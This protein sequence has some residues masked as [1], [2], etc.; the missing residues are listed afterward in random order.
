M[1]VTHQHQHLVLPQEHALSLRLAAQAQAAAA[2]A[3]TNSNVTS[4]SV[5]LLGGGGG[6]VDISKDNGNDNAILPSSSSS[7]GG[8]LQTRVISPGLVELLI[9]AGDPSGYGSRSWPVRVGGAGLGDDENDENDVALAKRLG[10]LLEERAPI[11]VRFAVP[12]ALHGVDDA[13][14][15]NASFWNTT[16]NDNDEL[17][18]NNTPT[19]MGIAQRVVQWLE[20]SHEEGNSK[21]WKDTERHAAEGLHHHSPL[22]VEQNHHRILRSY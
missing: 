7:S 19:L 22:L 12:I 4:T 14:F 20:G 8:L 11:A 15:C 5:L 13:G 17:R 18:K 9:Q 10:M 3:A 1:A 2:A 16:N 21:E 6:G